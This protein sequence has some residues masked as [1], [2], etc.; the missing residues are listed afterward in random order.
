MDHDSLN[1]VAHVFTEYLQD[2]LTW[3]PNEVGSDYRAE[4]SRTN[5]DGTTHRVADPMQST[6]APSVVPQPSSRVVDLM[7]EYDWLANMTSWEDDARAFHERSIGA[8]GNGADASA[9]ADLRPS[10]LY[11]SSNVRTS[12]FDPLEPNQGW[13][14]VDYGEGGNVVAVTV[15][16]QCTDRAPSQCVDT[17]TDDPAAREAQLLAGCLCA[18]EQH[19]QYRWDELNRLAEARRYDRTGGTGTWSLAARLR[20]RY[21]A[22]NTRL[23][24]QSLDPQQTGTLRERTHLFVFP[25]DFERVGLRTNRTAS[26]PRYV[27]ST[28]LGSETT[29]A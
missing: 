4:R 5:Q 12:G 25:G 26:P 23:V 28:A 22:A 9:A 18:S 6:P 8:I 19:Y 21:D 11:L 29:T 17:P 7:Y 1:R 13:L 16:A 14:D 27:A 24:K 20:Y 2:D 10:A 3:A 15:R